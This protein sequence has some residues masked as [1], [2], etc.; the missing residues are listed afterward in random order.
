MDE[1]ANGQDQSPVSEHSE[2]RGKRAC[3]VFP[4]DATS[5][6]IA[7]AINSIPGP[8]GDGRRRGRV[9]SPAPFVMFP[10]SRESC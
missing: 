5:K 1:E 10:E 8:E 9:T 2:P 4:R 3:I 7:E 6:Q